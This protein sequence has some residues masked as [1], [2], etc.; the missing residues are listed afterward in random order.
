MIAMT[1]AINK[2]SFEGRRE[3]TCYTCHHGMVHPQGAPPVL[4]TDAPPQH[5]APPATTA[6]GPTADQI[7]EKY[8]AAIGGQAA[9]NKAESRVAKGTLLMGGRE[10]PVEVISKAPN[11]RISTMHMPNGDSITAYDGN[12]GWMANPG[13]PVT[14]MSAAESDAAALDAE[15]H[16]ATR[17]KEIFKQLRVGRPEKVGDAQ[18]Q[19]LMGMRPGLPP[20]RLY[21]D[22]ASGLLVRMVRFTETP[23]GRMPTQIDYSDY[24][25]LD[26]LKVP[27]RW[28][29]AR[30]GGRFTIQ[31]ADVQQNVPVDDAKFAKPAAAN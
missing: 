15:L 25:P 1:M 20:V 3:V 5:E 10:M 13:R 18:C 26:G 23:L 30:P 14:P 4:E 22:E 31:I 11:K 8:V 27:L 2:N 21:F 17:V 19:V 24:K 9:V 28:T 6:A 16:F 12:S 29:I 7:L